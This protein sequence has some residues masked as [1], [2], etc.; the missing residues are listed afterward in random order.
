[1]DKV[2]RFIQQTLYIALKN[3]TIAFGNHFKTVEG[4]SGI[5]TALTFVVDTDTTA[6]HLL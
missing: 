3:G 4:R 1:L 5:P 2:F 6:I